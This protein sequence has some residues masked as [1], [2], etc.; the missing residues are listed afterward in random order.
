MARPVPNTPVAHCPSDTHKGV[1][2]ARLE[3]LEPPPCGHY[4]NDC[5][6]E[7]HRGAPVSSVPPQ[8]LR[9]SV[10]KNT[11]AEPWKIGSRIQGEDA[12]GN[13]EANACCG[14]IV[15]GTRASVVILHQTP[16]RPTHRHRGRGDHSNLAFRHGDGWI[17]PS[18][19]CFAARAPGRYPEWSTLAIWTHMNPTHETI[20][21]TVGPRDSVLFLFVDTSS[22]AP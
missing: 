14:V 15:D 1:T 4:L 7:I 3:P 13:S 19:P 5:V 21:E 17:P 22:R 8:A 12:A 9:D 11:Q 6:P 10:G 2:L 20:L 18:R 16:I